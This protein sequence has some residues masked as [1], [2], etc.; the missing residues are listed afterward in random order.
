MAVSITTVQRVS[1]AAIAAA[2]V[3]PAVCTTACLA[4]EL[5][6][7][8]SEAPGHE[9][10]VVPGAKDLD[11]EPIFTEFKALEILSVSPDGSQW[12][13]KGR[14]WLGDQLETM[15]LLGSGTEGEVFAQ[16]GQPVHD[17]EPGEVYEFFCSGPPH[18]NDL[19]QFVYTARARE[20][21]PDIKQK[22]IFFDGEAFHMTRRE[23]DPAY[24]LEDYPGY[25]VGD[26]LFGNSFG[27]FH[28]LNDGTI[29]CQDD[30]IKNIH[31]SY[32][33]AIFYDDQA[34]RQTSVSEIEGSI[35]DDIDSNDFWTTPD[36][37]TWIAQG[38]DMSPDNQDEILVV[39]D[40]VVLREGTP[41]VPGSEIIIA[42]ISHSKLAGDGSWFTRGDDPGDNDWAVRNGTL[43]A[44]TGDP[45]IIGS[46]EHWGD[47]FL[48]FT[49]NRMGDWVL[50]GNTD[51]GD[52]AIDE[53]LVVNGEI[54]VA[55]EGDPIDLDGNG[56]FDDDAF[57][58]RG[59]LTSS[60]FHADDIFLGDDLTLFF[61]ASLRN[62]AGEDLGSFG[63]GGD[64]FIRVL[65][66][67]ECPA[68]IT[69]DG[70]V[71]VL[72]LLEVLSQW[73]TSGDA[74]ITGDGIVDV[75]D[76]LEVLAAWGPCE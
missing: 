51:I 72:D 6:V 13:L 74:D 21:D 45:I 14:N 5:E 34:F 39:N 11:G 3:L 36:G 17:G 70:V 30:T 71:D 73:G 46:E 22:G 50:T 69:G 26:E 29:G 58:G 18:F 20:G 48:S 15:L 19:N 76:L 24:G 7:I 62:A 23:S 40:T 42:A 44:A 75:L 28:L 1:I 63:S 41:V 60:A 56:E 55:R 37:S 68:D 4:A 64:A 47:K 2:A 43:L 16:E 66:A 65:L 27:S 54:I 67:P 59:N 61:F 53:V 52:D 12:I 9:T 25:P 33:P 8:F 10:A 49:G 38:E 31:S 57:I 32:R 35:W